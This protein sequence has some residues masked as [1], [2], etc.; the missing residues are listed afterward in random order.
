MFILEVVKFI[1]LAIITY[2]FMQILTNKKK[3]ISIVGTILVACSSY[4]AWNGVPMAILLGEIIVLSLYYFMNSQ[5]KTKKILSI[6]ALILS[7][8]LMF[9]IAQF[10]NEEKA[11]LFVYVALVIWLTI[12]DFINNKDS[13]G[14]RIN[15]LISTILTFC[16][17]QQ[18]FINTNIEEL[19][20]Q[21]SGNGL[22]KLFTYG[23]SMFLPFV[24]IGENI[25]YAGF[26]S[27][28]P[29]SLIVAM[30]YVYQKE[31]H[32]DFLMPMIIVIVIESVLCMIKN[33]EICALA[34]GLGSI[35]LYIYMIA[36]IEEKVFSMKS[37]IKLVLG[38]LIFYFFIP[39]PNMFMTKAYMYIL[40]ML[41]TLLYFL[42]VNFY[43]ERY[44]KVL[45]IV[46]ALWS[47][48]SFVPAF[49]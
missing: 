22:S 40:A 27:I 17:L 41:I 32:L 28:F 12:K 1:V 8:I 25:N 13:F 34:V 42:F 45:L 19:L 11:M 31:K 36:N 39:R 5:S 7:I 44:Q 35:Y 26:L 37:S 46:L 43:D 24:D 38:L 48:M 20:N 30:I 16:L 49:I 4:I 29:L 9:S 21:N 6:L 3:N 47:I 18:V 23:Y 2:F 14:K 33:I 10:V 15:I